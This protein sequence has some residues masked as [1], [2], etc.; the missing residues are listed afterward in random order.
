M[1]GRSFDGITVRERQPFDVAVLAIASPRN[2]D[3]G[4]SMTD[5]GRW[6]IAVQPTADLSIS[7]SVEPESAAPGEALMWTVIVTNPGPSDAPFTEVTWEVPEG[8]TLEGTVG[9]VQDPVGAPSCGLGTVAAGTS[10]S[11]EATVDVNEDANGNLI[12]RFG[13]SSS[14]LDPNVIDN[15]ETSLVPVAAVTD[16]QVQI[17]GSP[18]RITPGDGATYTVVVENGGPAAADD[19]SLVLVP[20]SGTSIASASPCEGGPPLCR[21]ARLAAG[22]RIS[23]TVQVDTDALL[24][25]PARLE[26]QVSSRAGESNPGDETGVG[27]VPLD[28]EVD[29]ALSGS[30]ARQSVGIG[31]SGVHRLRVENSGPDGAPAVDVTWDARTGLEVVDASNDSVSLTVVA[32]EAGSGGGG[33]ATIREEGGCVCAAAKRPVSPWLFAGLAGLMAVTRRRRVN[34]LRTG[35]PAGPDPTGRPNPPTRGGRWPR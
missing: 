19:V 7:T 3:C 5:V 10:V 31:D 24:A 34:R 20:G 15:T 13:V 8:A 23:V 16:L 25:L 35:A 1:D 33:G 4:S 29:L 17:S 6:S 26:V 22:E 30:P 12:G 27:V 9:C 2:Q 28:A 32:A 11:F 21:L 18:E 14:A